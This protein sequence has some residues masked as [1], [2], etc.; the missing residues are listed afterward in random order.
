MEYNIQY[1]HCKDKEGN[2]ISINDISEENR[3]DKKLY[4]LSCGNEMIFCRSSLGT[5]FFR[6]KTNCSCDGETYLHLLAKQKIK[7]AF[8]DKSRPFYMLLR[9]DSPCSEYKTCF[10]FNDNCIYEEN[11]ASAIDLHRWY[12]TI[13]EEVPIDCFVADLLLTNSVKNYDPLFIEIF[14]THPCEASKVFSQYRIIEV[15]ITSE[16]DV[17][18][19]CKNG[20][21]QSTFVEDINSCRF[22]N[23]KL[24]NPPVVNKKEHSVFVQGTKP[25]TRFVVFSNGGVRKYDIGCDD[26]NNRLLLNTILEL[27]IRIPSFKECSDRYK[28]GFPYSS[29]EVA[30]EYIRR[31]GLEIKNCLMCKYH[32][33]NDRDERRICTLYKKYGTPK[34]PKQLQAANCSFYREK[35]ISLDLKTLEI[36]RIVQQVY[37]TK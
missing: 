25:W 3:H 11:L 8:E 28:G 13:S 36:S 30:F 24:K 37:P 29:Y 4:C 10:F 7:E 22:Y 19:I 33:Y 27:N 12:D 18:N 9:A 21:V 1:Q 17:E 14:V 32:N 26:I 34:E 20:F 15:P 2:I 5:P 16:K 23:I 35:E 6:H 31:C